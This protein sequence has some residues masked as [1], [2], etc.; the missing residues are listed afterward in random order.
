MK[1]PKATKLPSGSWRIQAQI[2]GVRYSFTDKD[3]KKVKQ[4][5]KEAFA[6]AEQEAKLQMTVGTA[7]DRYI[8]SKSAVLSPST[9]RGYKKYRAYYFQSIMDVNINALTQEMVQIAVNDEVKAGSSPKTIR[10]AHGLLS[11]VLKA[12]RPKLQLS[13]TLPQKERTE[14][15]IP[16]EQDMKLI[17][18]EA[19]G[20]KYELPI[21]LASWLG[22]RV[23]EIKGLKFSDIQGDKVHIHTAIV[24]D[25]D[26]NETSKRPKSY[27]GDRWIIFPDTIRELVDKSPHDS[28]YV[29]NYT[30]GSIYKAFKRICE[31]CNVGPYRFHD[32][33]HFAASEAHS[34]GIPDKY[35]MKRMG[36]KTDYMLKNVYLHT[37]RDKED[38]FANIIDQHMA[39][40][41]SDS[42]HEN[43]HAI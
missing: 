40:L 28:E 20:T 29:C 22:L 32:L 39:M 3:I 11:A 30:Y 9:I 14:I 24:L 15:S 12:Y 35:E 27:S 37:M 33:R 36:H 1:L 34:L 23:S 18:R 16:S 8:E 21:L 43:A 19:A 25:K 4:M 38:A 7:Y 10:N 26:G 41:F 17:W 2:D 13:T 42:A 5:A 6:G 31:R